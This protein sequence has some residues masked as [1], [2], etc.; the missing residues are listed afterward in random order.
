MPQ[1]LRLSVV[2]EH[3]MLAWSQDPN[4][5]RGQLGTSTGKS[6]HLAKILLGHQNRGIG[7]NKGTWRKVYDA[8]ECLHWYPLR[9]SRCPEELVLC[10][11]SA[12]SLQHISF[13]MIL[14]RILQQLFTITYP[15][16]PMNEYCQSIGIHFKLF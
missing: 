15:N 9:E 3:F 14:L 7:A 11:I 10:E 16:K 1:W 4:T 2:A 8:G 12:Q 13:I 6:S 5:A